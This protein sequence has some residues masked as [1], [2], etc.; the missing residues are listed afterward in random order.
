MKK[1][2]LESEQHITDRRHSFQ[3]NRERTSGNEPR[4]HL[5]LDEMSTQWYN[6]PKEIALANSVNSFKSKLNLYLNKLG[7]NI[8]S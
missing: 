5:L 7:G 2:I 4:K 1:K 3:L 6:L 8:Y